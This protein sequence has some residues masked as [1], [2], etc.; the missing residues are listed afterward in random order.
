MESIHLTSMVQSQMVSNPNKEIERDLPEFISF[1]TLSSQGSDSEVLICSVKG[2][3]SM[4]YIIKK[5]KYSFRGNEENNKRLLRLFREYQAL[6]LFD[7]P[8]ILKTYGFRAGHIF[9]DDLLKRNYYLIVPYCTEGDLD[10]FI[11]TSNPIPETQVKILLFDMLTGLLEMVARGITHRDIKPANILL[12]KEKPDHLDNT[13]RMRAIIADLG[14]LFDAN[15]RNRMEMS[16]FGT[17]ITLAPE[18]FPMSNQ[19]PRNTH[20]SDVFSL[21]VTVYLML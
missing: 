12:F 8:H 5:F 14:C 11:R 15:S 3:T 4:C 6:S 2:D 16:T 17:K 19:P 20:K 13:P 7:S 18:L 10:K 1:K 9:G 21:G